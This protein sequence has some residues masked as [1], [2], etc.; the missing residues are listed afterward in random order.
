MLLNL[1][2][3]GFRE[4]DQGLKGKGNRFMIITVEWILILNIFREVEEKL[5]LL[6][7]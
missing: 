2:K 6:M 5:M 4:E 1:Q 3:D 7:T